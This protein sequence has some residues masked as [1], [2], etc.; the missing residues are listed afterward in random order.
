MVINL[1]RSIWTS[2]CLKIVRGTSWNGIVV[3]FHIFEMK[4][5]W[6]AVAMSDL[7]HDVKGIH[8]LC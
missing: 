3:F 5:V 4:S 1:V 7:V 8:G 6:F 2:D